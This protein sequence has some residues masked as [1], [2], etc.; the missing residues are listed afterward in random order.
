MTPQQIA[1]HLGLQD[2]RFFAQESMWRL[3][4]VRFKYGSIPVSEVMHR[5]QGHST[6]NILAALSR[7]TDTDENVLLVAHSL[8]MA[9]LLQ[10]QAGD[11]ALQLGLDPRRI[12]GAST[13]FK[14]RMGWDPQQVFVDHVV[15]EFPIAA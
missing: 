8:D 7:L 4:D 15:H 9:K 5:Q 6:R 3:A 1:D 2:F 12:K 10:K 14:G 13:H 11:W